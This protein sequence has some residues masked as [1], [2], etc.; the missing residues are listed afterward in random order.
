MPKFEFRTLAGTL[1]LLLLAAAM[2]FTAA[3]D[4]PEAFS[5][6]DSFAAHAT[7]R[8]QSSDLIVAPNGRYV[9][10]IEGP[11]L[12]VATAPKFEARTVATPVVAA[13]ATSDG[14]ALLFTRGKIEPAFGPYPEQD[15]REMWRVPVAGGTPQLLA[16]GQE[17]PKGVPVFATDGRSFVTVEGP[18]IYQY[19]LDGEG[20]QGRPLLKRDAQHYSAIRLSNLTYSPDGRKLAFVSW[21]KAGQSYV[22]VHDLATGD[23][24]YIDPGIFR[25]VTPVWSPD[26]SQLAFA[27]TLG[28]WT[29]EYRFSPKNEAAPWSLVIADA[30]TG[31]VRTLWRADPGKGSVFQPFGEG[32]W[33][34]SS[35]ETPQLSW[36]RG[37]EILFPWEKT[38]WL[39]LYAIAASGGKPKQITPGEGEVTLPA[40]DATGQNV[41][42]ATNIGD[43]PRLHLWRASLSGG[44][45][46]PLTRGTGVEHSPK[47]MADDRYVYIDNVNGRMPNRR[48]IATGTSRP[49]VLT[50]RAAEQQQNQKLWQQFV[51]EEVVALTAEDGLVSYHMMMVPKGKPPQGGFPVIVSSKG[52]PDGRV[53]PG[54]TVNAALGQYAASRGYIFIDINYR[55][56]FGFGLDYR[57]PPERGATGGSEVKDLRALALYLRGR[58]DVN[59]NRIGILGGSYGGHIVG[60]AMT[61][62]PEYFRAAV[63][64]SGVSD[65]VLEMQMDQTEDGWASAPPEYI[66]LSER[67]KIEDLAFASSSPARIGAW[68]GPTLITM[69]E[70]DTSGHMQG[71]IDLGYRLIKQGTHVEFH[72]APEAGHSG[73]RARPPEKAFEFLQRELR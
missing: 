37:G 52:G 71:I 61:Q 39:S 43:L 5:L 17:V 70:R 58:A 35:V 27:R 57:F 68:R 20:L 65:W 55:G 11:D 23:Y 46:Q 18:M 32:A 30:A 33:M 72:I 26:S 4:T 7:L 42:Y 21:R 16:K 28:N 38:G 69:G 40:L 1:P 51:D 67:E 60:L 25:D 14:Q 10:W 2:S 3:A 29:H 36:T 54:N 64:M 31:K 6:D 13:Y 49:T 44:S 59:P 19:R 34:E 73:R 63:H 50:P 9:A 53:S 66:R 22:A 47:M 15:S 56:C 12:L 62:L 48:V 8:L 45:P 41:I 24:R